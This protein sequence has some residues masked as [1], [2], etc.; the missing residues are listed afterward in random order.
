MNYSLELVRFLAV[1]L[2]TFT[3][4][5][6]NFSSGI[7][8]FIFEKLP[9][10]GTVMLSIVSGYLF[11]KSTS[12]KKIFFLDKF[13]NLF[14]PYIIANIGVLL[15]V[16]I[17]YGMFGVNFLNRLAFD[18][19]LITEG[20]FSLSSPPINPP[21]YFIRDLF[22]IFIVIELFKNNYWFM[23]L[24]IIPIMIFGRLFINTS[25]P[26]MFIVGALVS[27][28]SYYISKQK[29]IILYSLGVACIGIYF[30]YSS[31]IEVLKYFIAT[32]IFILIYDCKM[33]FINVGAYTYLLHLYHSPIMVSTA[34]LIHK[35]MNN[36]VLYVLC[37]ILVAILITFL[38]FVA[39]R[40][41]PFLKVLS[42]GK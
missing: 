38:L 1:I 31:E 40:K 32:W 2:I 29:K 13:K 26:L 28:Y 18:Y 42:G 11:Q 9:Q 12:K 39:T 35:F 10:V 23:L 25:I 14:I 17:A 16:L 33:N 15:L 6:N 3:H 5:R 22:I 21:T 30:F 20:I 8:L 37:Q 4:T 24:I 7:E 41:I 27:Y 36:D 19:S 34:P